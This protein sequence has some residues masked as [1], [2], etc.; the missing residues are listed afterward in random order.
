MLVIL[1][2]LHVI[3]VDLFSYWHFERHFSF[4]DSKADQCVSCKIRCGRFLLIIFGVIAFFRLESDLK[5]PATLYL[6][7]QVFNCQQRNLL[8][9]AIKNKGCCAMLALFCRCTIINREAHLLCFIHLYLQT[10][11]KQDL[12]LCDV[13]TY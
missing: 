3:T 10:F 12:S 13:G 8:A 5:K 7:L 6:P 9:T 1:E 11:A 2:S 4:L